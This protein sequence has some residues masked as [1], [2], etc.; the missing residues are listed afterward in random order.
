MLA[1]ILQ[2]LI[3]GMIT[4]I[5]GTIIF[6][7]SINKNNKNCEQPYGIDLAF[8]TTGVILYLV[9]ELTGCNE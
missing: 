7:L 2:S 4:Y 5:M 9:F 1:L 3:I 8:F 6:N